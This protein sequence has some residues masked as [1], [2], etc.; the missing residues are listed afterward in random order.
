MRRAFRLKATQLKT[1]EIRAN[2][3][4]FREL[5]ITILHN[6]VRFFTDESGIQSIGFNGLW[7]CALLRK[8]IRLRTLIY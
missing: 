8:I 4:T 2:L 3:I 7:Y 6:F 5:V 1:N